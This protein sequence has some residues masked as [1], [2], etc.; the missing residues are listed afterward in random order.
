MIAGRRRVL[1]QITSAARPRLLWPM[2]ADPAC[3]PLVQ[4]APR[5]A[6]CAHTPRPWRENA[7]NRGGKLD[8]AAP[9][10]TRPGD[11]ERPGPLARATPW[12]TGRASGLSS[13]S[14]RRPLPGRPVRAVVAIG[15]HRT[16]GGPAVP[17]DP[18]GVILDWRAH[19]DE[20]RHLVSSHR[21]PDVAAADKE[22]RE[23]HTTHPTDAR[24]VARMPP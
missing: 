4:G 12:R 23:D 9:A 16:T 17:I 22:H 10:G 21:L 2:A 5:A 7:I 13:A 3:H 19:E 11:R 1:C 24:R 18:D 15:G 14:G 6:R 8:D 20:A